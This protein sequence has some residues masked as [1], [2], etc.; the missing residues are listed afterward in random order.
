MDFLTFLS[1]VI[2][3]LAWPATVAIVIFLVR[4]QLPEIASS[5]KSIKYKDFE[6][7]FAKQVKE[8]VA[9]VREALPAWD[10]ATKPGFVLDGPSSQHTTAVSYYSPSAAILEAW[11][12]IESAAADLAVKLKPNSVPRY[13]SPLKLKEVL[14]EAGIFNRRQAAAFDSL[15][16]IRNQVVHVPNPRFSDDTVAE[17]LESAEAMAKYVADQHSKLP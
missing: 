6:M 5:L 9:E 8:A 10:A 14:V 15:R 4:K 16:T 1:K 7:S 13:P 2:D 3:A 12:K 17:Y 11:L